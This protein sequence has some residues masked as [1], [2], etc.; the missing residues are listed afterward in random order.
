[1][2]SNTL[3]KLTQDKD[4]DE[5]LYVENVEIPFFDNFKLPVTFTNNTQ[6]FI[7]ESD[8]A[9]KNFLNLSKNDR[10]A[11]SDLIY[12]NCRNFLDDIGYDEL[13]KD[14]WEI[15]DKDDIWNFVTPTNIYVEK[16][17]R[18]DCDFYIQVTCECAW[19]QEHGLQLVFRQGKKI[20]R[21]SDQDGHLTEA[22][23]YDKPDEEDKLLSEF[24]EL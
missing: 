11:I 16:R 1:M 4:V 19:E 20:T 22:D 8:F 15:T 10:L 21:V 5:W 9:V 6:T 3:G 13:D 7:N 12:Q 18:R 23:A 17:H 14:L 2:I 24:L